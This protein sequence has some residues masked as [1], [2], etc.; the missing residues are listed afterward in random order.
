MTLGYKFASFALSKL[1]LQSLRVYVSGKNL[2]TF[3]SLKDFDPEGEGV[4]DQPL[5]RLFVLG[6]NI[7]F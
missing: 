5:N 3:S 6:L 1:K 4:I 7:G 2:H